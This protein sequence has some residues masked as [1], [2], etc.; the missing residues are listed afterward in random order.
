MRNLTLL[1][2]A[3]VSS[4]TAF[5]QNVVLKPE[6]EVTVI[7]V[8]EK[9][10]LVVKAFDN[11]GNELKGGDFRYFA[12]QLKGVAKNMIFSKG[13]DVDSVGMADATAVGEY[14]VMVIR[15]PEKGEDFARIMHK[16]RVV[17]QEVAEISA[18][19]HPDPIYAG[20]IAT[21]NVVVKDKS[22]TV[23]ENPEVTAISS[24]SEVLEV[25]NLYNVFA[26]KPG[27]ATVTFKTGELISKLELEVLDN[28]VADIKIEVD[29]TTAR[30]GDVLSFYCSLTDKAGKKISDI[31][32][33]YTVQGVASEP[34]SGSAATIL[35]NRFVAEKAGTY[36][37][38]ASTGGIS[39]SKAIKVVDRGIARE[40]NLKGHGSVSDQHT[41]DLWVW[42]GI[43]GKDY[44]V[45]GTWGSNGKA[46]FWD[47]TDP[48][49]ITKIDSVQVDARTVNDVK[50]SEDGRT[51]VI[52]REGASNRKNGIII[53]DVSNP[54]DVKILAEYTD[55]LTG[56]V[57]NLFIY[58]NHVYAL[59]NSERYEIINIEN[60]KK[61]KRVG[62][63]VLE[64][65]AK[66]IHDVW[67]V[68]GIAYSSNWADGVAMVDVGNGVAG[69]TPEK[70]VEIAR[71][72]IF[73]DAN[74]AAFPY[75]SKG[76]GK[77][78]IIAGDEI[79][80]LAA[81]EST[82]FEEVFI[83]A[84]YLHFIDITDPKNPM[85]VARYEVPEAGSHNFW[86]ED[87]MLYIG[88]YNGG[89]RVVD[90]SGDL[91][92]D[93]Y[94]QGREIAS[95]KPYDP[96]GFVPNSPFVWGAQ[97]HKGH[98]FFSDFNSGLW[99][100]QV[101]PIVPEDTKIETR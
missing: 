66:S 3:V 68:D 95:Y 23:V 7:P 35:G 94:K 82:N 44:A 48:T 25:D 38:T 76:T 62:Q 90:I 52:S 17:N 29:Q 49:S 80:P 54:R 28:P 99:S 13:L 15:V 75:H 21:L 79:F 40:V 10:Q 96:K 12:V 24:N 55:R 31:P 87:D 88:Y 47:V 74:H 46:Y 8:N 53:I 91:M 65:S 16:V 5:A 64:N 22:G 59:S 61:P 72:H 2:F 33:Q 98:I 60:P 86:V 93:L 36:V 73:G 19:G 101:E 50:I 32:I 39:S 18:T 78:Y 71:A 43:D 37:V 30:T 26:L 89:L 27:K 1:L 11:D 57:H 63:F 83:P 77:K 97:P 20:T 42:E 51:C 85:E 67:I 45:T 92:G 58:K 6:S 56:G 70:P 4:V 84:G 81:M 100:V 9:K 14:D 34:G 41:S 69:G